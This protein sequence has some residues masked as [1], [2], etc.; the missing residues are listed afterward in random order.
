VSATSYYASANR[1]IKQGNTAGLYEMTAT[2][3]AIAEALDALKSAPWLDVPWS[4]VGSF[5]GHTGLLT[6][7]DKTWDAYA[8]CTNID[9]T[10]G[11]QNAR[12]GC[13]AYRIDLPAAAYAQ[14]AMLV[15]VGVS[16][17][18]DPYLSAGA[19]VAVKL[20]S[21]ATPS[22]DWA[23]I[24]AGDSYAAAVAPRTTA[25]VNGLTRWYPATSDQTITLNANGVQS[26]RY[27]WIY[28]SL[29][30][31][32]SCS[33]MP[34]I[35]GG[36]SLSPVITL[37][38]SSAVAGLIAGTNI[39]GTVAMPDLA[40]NRVTLLDKS[41]GYYM[42]KTGTKCYATNAERINS[43]IANFNA[44]TLVEATG[45][46]VE[47]AGISAGVTWRYD[48]AV[49]VC[50]AVFPVTVHIPAGMP[51]RSLI[52]SRPPDWTGCSF[53]LSAYWVPGPIATVNATTVPVDDHDFWMGRA[54]WP[55]IAGKSACLL[56]RVI[57]TSRPAG[58]VSIPVS[59]PSSETDKFGSIYIIMMPVDVVTAEDSPV[60]LIV[61]GGLG[62]PP[63]AAPW[64]A[65]ITS[66]AGVQPWLPTTVSLSPLAP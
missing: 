17:S 60:G 59:W 11:A 64:T 33:R 26:L 66:S 18:G 54:H 50:A 13:V 29:E 37:T 42:L 44:P 58:T 40:C 31:Y 20:S 24:I 19:R 49:I 47:R 36:A 38:Y 30:N 34:W 6:D 3:P 22:T 8:V 21:S 53:V 35:E 1:Y 5:P 55:S 48:V 15:S 4:I 32:A 27:I 45:T 52:L 12:L 23:T 7:A 10:T 39:G 41:F 61:L 25:V 57:M 2:A 51:I 62:Y 46:L 14:G 16:V 65:T 9:A 28:L 63:S 56:G 43:L